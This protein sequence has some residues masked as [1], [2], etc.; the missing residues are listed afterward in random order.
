MK[1]EGA[2]G[3]Q[4]R[5][6][7]V[8]LGTQ[9]VQVARGTGKDMPKSRATKAASS[10]GLAM[11]NGTGCIAMCRFLGR[12]TGDSIDNVWVLGRGEQTKPPPTIF[13]QVRCLLRELLPSPRKAGGKRCTGTASTTRTAGAAGTHSLIHVTLTRHSHETNPHC[14]EHLSSA[15]I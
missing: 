12:R 2:E 11:V 3:A 14:I 4:E 10:E 13:L 6:V 5:A 1:G 9:K 15:S 8:L 7:R